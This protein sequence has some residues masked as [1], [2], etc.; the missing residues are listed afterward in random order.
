MECGGTAVKMALTKTSLLVLAACLVTGCGASSDVPLDNYLT[1]LG[2]SLDRTIEPTVNRLPPLP[3]ARDLQFDLRSGSINLLEMLALRGC[4]LSITIG[5]SN[6]SLGKLANDSQRLLLEL[7]FLS[8]APA[9]ID[10]LD[11]TGDAELI[12]ILQ[13]A[14]ANKRRQLP[15]RVW[16]AT[17]G[18]PEFRAFWKRPGSLGNY[19]E[20]T[21][22]QIVTALARLAELSTRWLDGDYQA[23]SEELEIL[24][25]DVRLGDGGALLASLELQRAGLASAAPAL[26]DRT[27]RAPICLG[28]A[29]SPEGKIVDTV[30]R[31]FFIGEVQPWSVQLARRRIELMSPVLALELNLAKVVP[32]AYRQWSSRRDQLLE[33]AVQAPRDHARSLA[34][35]L[36]ICGL[37]P[38]VDPAEP[39]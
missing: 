37:R 30:V 6:S 11:P 31:K 26:R 29:P 13:E 25:S 16:N 3:R 39:G 9:C 10:S 36:E 38:G 35:L 17:L 21:G 19:P 14:V 2:R 32:P 7:E 23:G 1:R 5:K 15:A 33:S 12:T 4:E 8:L 24:L 18:G 22:S 20:N 28:K 27:E 34:D